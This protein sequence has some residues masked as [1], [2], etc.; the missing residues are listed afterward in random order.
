MSAVSDNVIVTGAS[1]FVGMHLA[2]HFA[3]RGKGVFA[4]TSKTPENYDGVRA[5]RIQTLQAESIRI[6]QAD[7][8]DT[9]SCE[10]LLNE[11]KP[12]LW[13]HHAGFATNYASFDYDLETATRINLLPLYRLYPLFAQKNVRVI[14][15]GSVSEY[16][17]GPDA[18]DESD[19]CYPATPYGLSKLSQTLAVNQLAHEYKVPTRVARLFIPF[20]RLDNPQKLMAQVMDALKNDHS[21]DLTS[22][23][24]RRDFLGATDMCAAYEALAND[25]PRTLFDVFNVCSGNAIE[26][27]KF[28]T[29]IAS[30]MRKDP[31][32][33][34]FGKREKRSS[35]PDVIAGTNAKALRLLNWNPR[36]LSQALKE[37]LLN[38]DGV[39]SAA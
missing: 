31:G 26:L 27:K 12:S 17:D 4:V 38:E 15:T 9:A 8:T 11:A 16:A 25:M 20:G 21:V 30:L 10:R 19:A 14:L 6:F 13:I 29:E 34:G 33:L 22:C 36:P 35:E 18:H 39:S 24:Q 5:A 3:K 23:D 32:L 28:L 2:R 7:L 1:S 37:D